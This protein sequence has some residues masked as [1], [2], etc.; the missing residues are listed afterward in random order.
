MACGTSKSDQEKIMRNFQGSRFLFLELHNFRENL[1]GISRGKV[2]KKI[3]GSFQKSM[4]STLLFF[5][6]E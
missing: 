5:F 1:S 6:P 3:Q 4:S 2:N